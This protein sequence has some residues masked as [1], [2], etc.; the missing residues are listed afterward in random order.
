[1]AEKPNNSAKLAQLSRVRAMMGG[2]GAPAAPPAIE[3]EELPADVEAPGGAGD[4]ATA[5]ASDGETPTAVVETIVE[6]P[7]AA[8]VPLPKRPTAV[9]VAARPLDAGAMETATRAPASVAA[10]FVAQYASPASRATMAAGL[11]RCAAAVGLSAE[12]L[13]WETLRAADTAFIRARLLETYPKRKTVAISLD[14][15]RGVLRHAWRLGRI[16]TDEYQRAIDLPR[17]PKAPDEVIAGRELEQSEIDAMRAWW[18]GEET[19]YR[20]FVGATFSLMLGVGLRVDEVCRLPLGAYDEGEQLLDVVRKGRK[21]VQLPVGAYEHRQ[22]CR[23]AP[24]RREMR[25]VDVDRLLVRVQSN[26]WCRPATAKL[27]RKKVEYL[28]EVIARELKLAPF[29]PHDCRRTF[30]TR[31]RRAGVDLSVRQWL[32]SHED[33]KTTARYDRTK[34]EE[35]SALRARVDLWAPPAQTSTDDAATR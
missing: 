9:V 4:E 6:T 20:A 8:I 15:L 28:C 19:A 12:S 32:M 27:D 1:M 16:P 17:L 31:L 26:D 7:T 21:E 3:R 24:F 18:E 35:Y 30:A 5:D 23:W 14:A 29:T 10:S 22:L 33:P 34:L 11:R 2:R 13:P 25:L